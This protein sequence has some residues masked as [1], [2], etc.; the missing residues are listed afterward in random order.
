MII[1]KSVHSIIN[2]QQRYVGFSHSRSHIGRC[3]WNSICLAGMNLEGHLIWDKN[4]VPCPD[5]I[6]ILGLY[7]K[8]QLAELLI[9]LY[10]WCVSKQVSIET[11]G[12]ASVPEVC[13]KLSMPHLQWIW[14]Q[15]LSFHESCE[16]HI[17]TLVSSWCKKETKLVHHATFT[18]DPHTSKPQLSN[19]P[20]YPN[21]LLMIFLV[22]FKWK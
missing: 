9:T 10:R 8:Q 6:H 7:V 15:Y 18:A 4:K 11:F 20:D 5:F 14:G 21:A 19:L 1:E 17:K 12:F 16:M 3:S 22:H 2:V 13:E